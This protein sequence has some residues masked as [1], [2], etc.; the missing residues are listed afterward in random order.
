[1]SRH[2]AIDDF[3]CS[4]RLERLAHEEHHIPFSEDGLRLSAMPTCA[5]FAD[6]V[7][8]H[9]WWGACPPSDLLDGLRLQTYI[10]LP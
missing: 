9:T 8:M 1:M 3:L 7:G 4:D 5:G 2:D 10:P 6:Q